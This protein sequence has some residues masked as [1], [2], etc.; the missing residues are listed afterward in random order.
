MAASTLSLLSLQPSPL[1]VL[2]WFS[3][4]TW[5][6][7]YRSRGHP[8]GGKLIHLSKV[9]SCSSGEFGYSRGEREDL[10]PRRSFCHA[11][12]LR[13]LL[14]YSAWR[15][16]SAICW[17][18]QC[19]SFAFIRQTCGERACGSSMSPSSSPSLQHIGIALQTC[20]VDQR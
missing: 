4:K 8:W 15:A 6:V 11:I 3:L 14:P 5:G 2:T 18:F 9:A 13:F 17:H 7:I 1:R 16:K 20:A 12:C 10:A 19:G